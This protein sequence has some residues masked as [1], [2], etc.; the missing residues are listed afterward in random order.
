MFNTV[1]ELGRVGAL[2]A[3]RNRGADLEDRAQST[4]RTKHVPVHF[5]LASDKRRGFVLSEP[6]RHLRSDS[7]DFFVRQFSLV[8]PSVS[9]KVRAFGDAE[10]NRGHVGGKP[11]MHLECL[12]KRLCPLNLPLWATDA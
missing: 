2:L 1:G 10:I 5:A 11:A 6:P 7:I 3:S 8:V 12:M 9:P 4:D